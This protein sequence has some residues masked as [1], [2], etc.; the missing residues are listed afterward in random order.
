MYRHHSI[1]HDSGRDFNQ[2][3]SRSRTSHIAARPAGWIEFGD[4]LE[5]NSLA[6]ASTDR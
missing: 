2:S 3:G 4:R 6:T 5:A 1:H